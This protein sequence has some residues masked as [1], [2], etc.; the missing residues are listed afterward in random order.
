MS[1]GK[2][3]GWDIGN[4]LKKMCGKLEVHTTNRSED[5]SGIRKFVHF[6][7]KFLGII[8][9]EFLM[10][11]CKNTKILTAVF[12]DKIMNFENVELFTYIKLYPHI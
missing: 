9:L 1:F 3:F 10:K 4:V 6:S 8:P 12:P 2:I 5:I 11:K 7:C